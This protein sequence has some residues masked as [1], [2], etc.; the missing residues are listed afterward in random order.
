MKSSGSYTDIQNLKIWKANSINFLF[1]QKFKE[2]NDFCK[3]AAIN[4]ETIILYNNFYMRIAALWHNRLKTRV[5]Q[6]GF[7]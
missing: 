6:T 4:L 3:I 2:G 1:M 7:L 5:F